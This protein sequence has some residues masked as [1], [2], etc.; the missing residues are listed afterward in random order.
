MLGL[1]PEINVQASK[2]KARE[3]LSQYKRLTRMAGVKLTD[4]QSPSLDGMPKSPSFENK[5]EEKIV[6]RINA[7]SVISDIQQ[8]MSVL[9][10]T[11]YWVLYYSYFQATPLTYIQIADK[12]VGYSEESID[13]LKGRA[14]LEF[15][16]AYPNQ[17]LLVYC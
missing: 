10:P 13:Y 11:S 8:A 1:L 6:K 12:L 2:D 5:A 14:L 3:L 15:A 17:E 4:I 9:A 16:E 7:E